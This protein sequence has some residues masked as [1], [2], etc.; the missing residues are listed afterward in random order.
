M[1]CIKNF[2]IIGAETTKATSFAGNEKCKEILIPFSIAHQSMLSTVVQGDAQLERGDYKSAAESYS[3]A[4]E[5]DPSS[6]VFPASKAKALF[7]QQL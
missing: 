2:I 1:H 5:L 3:K 6:A 4:M 7:Q